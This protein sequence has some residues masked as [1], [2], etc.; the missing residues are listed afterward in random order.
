[1]DCLFCKIIDGQLESRIVY[2]DDEVLAILDLFPATTG[3]TLVMPKKHI[4]NCFDASEGEV[5]SLMAKA[6]MLAKELKTKLNASGM[7]VLINN[8][9]IAGQVIPHLHV[10][11]IPRYDGT[12]NILATS[13]DAKDYLDDTLKRIIND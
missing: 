6:T 8:E 7:N 11:L 1:M 12:E 9:P 3:H 13:Q 4:V 2:E 5:A 10:H